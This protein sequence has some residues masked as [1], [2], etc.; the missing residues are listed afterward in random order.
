MGRKFNY[1]QKGASEFCVYVRKTT[2]I[3]RKYT[4]STFTVSKT[5]GHVILKSVL[6]MKCVFRCSLQLQFETFSA[7]TTICHVSL[8]MRAVTHV[9]LQGKGSLYLSNL[10]EKVRHFLAEGANFKFH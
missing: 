6:N 3:V 5:E 7:P 4:Y 1:R 2:H 10:T 8:E 9:G